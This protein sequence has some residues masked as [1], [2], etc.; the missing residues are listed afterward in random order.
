MPGKGTKT[1]STSLIINHNITPVQSPILLSSTFRA[2][3]PSLPLG[4]HTRAM[5]AYSLLILA[6]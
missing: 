5:V 3:H 1:K 6:T 2:A 4:C